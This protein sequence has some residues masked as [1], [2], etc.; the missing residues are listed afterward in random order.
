MAQLAAY[1]DLVRLP[2]SFWVDPDGKT[3][4]I[5]PFEGGNPNGRLFRSR[6][7]A[8]H[9]SAPDDWAWVSSGSAD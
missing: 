5:H 9:H 2:G 6:R 7:A 3:V 8:A 1:E 4:H